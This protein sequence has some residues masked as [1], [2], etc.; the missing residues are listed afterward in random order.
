MASSSC[1]EYSARRHRCHQL[2]GKNNEDCLKEELEE[3]RCLSFHYCPAEA[4]AYYGWPLL[5]PQQQRRRRGDNNCSN[6][7]GN[8][9]TKKALCSS[10]AEA[11]YF[12]G[13]GS[14]NVSASLFENSDI[15]RDPPL[16]A[17]SDHHVKARDLVNGSVRLRSE[18][19][20]ITLDLAKCLQRKN[21]IQY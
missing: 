2:Y 14:N 8:G 3:K 5:E 21:R 17:V 10:W 6:D 20:A 13:D 11:F 18:C 1:H 4:K 16:S 7:R 9:A 12:A 19:R 15:N